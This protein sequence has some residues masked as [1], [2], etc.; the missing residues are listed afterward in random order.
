MLSQT[1]QRT[2]NLSES[3][4]HP[5]WRII[6]FPNSVDEERR[7]PF[8]VNCTFFFPPPI[9]RR[10][11]SSVA[12]SLVLLLPRLGETVTGVLVQGLGLDLLSSASRIFVVTLRWSKTGRTF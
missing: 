12:V 1:Q 7:G 10:I 9:S 4:Q 3:K 5:F 8:A 11:R 2:T 6:A